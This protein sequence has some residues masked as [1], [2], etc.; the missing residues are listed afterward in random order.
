MYVVYLSAA[1]EQNPK[2]ALI[3]AFPQWGEGIC[4]LLAHWERTEGEGFFGL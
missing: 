4:G 3:L 2:R 1:S